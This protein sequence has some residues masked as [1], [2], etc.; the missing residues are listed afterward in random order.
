VPLEDPLKDAELLVRSR[1]PFLLVQSD[2]RP[3][4]RSLIRLLADRMDIP[5]FRWTRARG[6]VRVDREGSVYETREPEKALRHITASDQPALYL[7]DGLETVFPGSSLFQ[8]K[9]EE[10]L[11]RLEELRGAI[12][13]TGPPLELTPGLRPR[14]SSVPLPGPSRTEL[15]DLLRR[16]IRDLNRKQHVEVELSRSDLNRLLDQLQGLTFMEAEK[17]ITRA[18]LEDGRLGVGDLRVV[19][20]AKR[21]IIEQ[22]GLLEYYPAEDCLAQV[23]GLDNLKRWL[24]RRQALVNDPEGAR[25]FGLEFPRG[26]LLTGV[27]GCGKSL[28]ARAVATEWELPLLRLDPASLSNRYIGETEKNLSRAVTL[29]EEMA[30]VV[31]WIDELEKAF[32]SSEGGEDGGVSRRILGSFLNWMQERRGPVFLVATA[33]QVDQIPP[34]LLRKGR[35]DEIFFVD[36]PGEEARA[37][38]LRIHLQNRNRDPQTLDLARLARLTDGFSGAELEQVVVSALYAAFADELAFDTDLLAREVSDTRPLSVTAAERIQGLRAW[39]RDRTTPA[40]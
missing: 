32:S 12:I 21:R 34:E 16:I 13:H 22:D 31:L 30:P 17:I 27:P 2:D 10:A 11:D 1:H 15:K 3:R 25:E 40:A 18:I 39:A 36:L 38:I 35:F 6:L 9:V 33:N 26:I 7:F 19:A 23:A 5:L 28:C 4:A 37:E 29:A 8:A 24:G 14:A 20:E